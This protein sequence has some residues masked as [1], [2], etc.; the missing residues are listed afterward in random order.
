MHIDL[1][2]C[3]TCLHRDI[4][5]KS[6]LTQSHD[7]FLGFLLTMESSHLSN[8]TKIKFSGNALIHLNPTPPLQ[9]STTQP[10]LQKERR[11]H[12]PH[13]LPN[14]ANLLNL[15][16]H[17]SNQPQRTLVLD[18]LSN[19]REI[20]QDLLNGQ[21]TLDYKDKRRSCPSD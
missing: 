4:T 14:Q 13:L 19:Q 5:K 16:T 7:L 12:Q 1:Y 20:C 8:R 18:N 11:W 21:N 9:T 15:R 6:S 3:D 2:F 10:W 17:Y